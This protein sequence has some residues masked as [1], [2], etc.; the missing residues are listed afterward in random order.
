MESA[1]PIW[2][3]CD[4]VFQNGNNWFI[5]TSE[6][7]HIGPYRE[8]AVAQT[9]SDEFTRRLRRMVNDGDR[10]RY[11]RTLLRQE[12]DAI[13]PDAHLDAEEISLEGMDD[14][15]RQGETPKRWYRSERFFQ[16]DSIWFFTTREGVDVGPFDS[17]RIARLHEV[18][19]KALLVKCKDEQ[20][21]RQMVTQYKHR[22]PRIDVN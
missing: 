17:E 22:P 13:G 18:R 6:S 16:V 1:I 4:Q 11:V 15:V 2:F 3:Q 10:L 21:A 9:K 20:S 12:W 5:G 14:P 7:L 19:L 8:E